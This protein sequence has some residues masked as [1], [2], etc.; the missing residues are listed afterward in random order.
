MCMAS[1]WGDGPP[2]QHSPPDW[3]T[4]HP[5]YGPLK[6]WVGIW[7]NDWWDDRLGKKIRTRDL[8]HLPTEPRTTSPKGCACLNHCR[9]SIGLQNDRPPPT[10]LTH[11]MRCLEGWRHPWPQLPPKKGHERKV[12]SNIYI[13]ITKNNQMMVMF[14]SIVSIPSVHMFAFH[15]PTRLYLSFIAPIGRNNS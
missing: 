8:I 10:H 2:D 7:L 6:Y 1:T 11:N 14:P 12:D 5:R 3:P 4:S 9:G 13:F 15:L